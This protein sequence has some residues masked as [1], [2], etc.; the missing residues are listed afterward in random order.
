MVGAT[1]AVAGE[2]SGAGAGGEVVPA[3]KAEQP[4]IASARRVAPARTCLFIESPER[5]YFTCSYNRG[6][7]AAPCCT[8]QRLRVTIDRATARTKRETC[9]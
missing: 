6:S 5:L 3:A 4:H 1:I 8:T 7:E 2:L 9:G